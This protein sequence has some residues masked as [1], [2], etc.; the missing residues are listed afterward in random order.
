YFLVVDGGRGAECDWHF[1]S[2][3]SLSATSNS[4]ICQGETIRLDVPQ[5]APG[6]RFF[7]R[8]PNGFVSTEK[9]PVIP[10]ATPANAG[11]YKVQVFPPSG[12]LCPDTFTTATEVVVRP[13]TPL[14]FTVSPPNPCAGQEV[15]ITYTGPPNIRLLEWSF[16]GGT[17]S[18][19]RGTGPFRVRFNEPGAKIIAVKTSEANCPPTREVTITVT[20]L[21]VP[22]FNVASN[23]ICTNQTNTLLFTGNAP[24]NST[25]SWNC[26]GCVQGS[27]S[28]P[29]PHG[30]SWS[31]AG[32]KTLS[33]VITNGGCRSPEYT[34][35][36]TVNAGPAAEF[37]LSGSLCESTPLQL[38]YQG[39]V[40][41]PLMKFEWNCDGCTPAPVNT[42]GPFTIS[43]NTSGA[44]IISL[45]VTRLNCTSQKVDSIFIHP[46][47]N[48]QLS[49]VPNTACEQEIVQ[50]NATVSSATR[51]ANFV[52]S[53]QGCQGQ[54]FAGLGTAN[55]SWATAGNKNVSFFV[56]DI[57]GCTSNTAIQNV[58][59]KPRPIASFNFPNTLCADQV[60]TLS[61]TGRTFTPNPT[62]SWEC[63]GCIGL[64]NSTTAGPFSI[65]WES[66][67]NKTLR[68]Q[69]EEQGCNSAVA[70]SNVSVQFVPITAASNSPICQ[71]TVLA[72]TA[73]SLPGAL[74]RWSG[75]LGFASNFSAPS[76]ANISLEAAGQ[77]SVLAIYNNC[78]SRTTIAKVEV[79]PYPASLKIQADTV[80][81]AGSNFS[82]NAQTTSVDATFL[83]SGPAGFTSTLQNPVIMSVNTQNAGTYSLIA[84]LGNCAAPL[85]THTLNVRS[86]A[87]PTTYADTV[88]RCETG[89]V[90]FTVNAPL[91]NLVI[92]YD[93]NHNEIS[94]SSQSPHILST[95][96]A[97]IGI[98]AFWIRSQ[99]RE[100]CLS[101]P[102][103]VY[104]KAINRPM[105]PRSN[106]AFRCGEGN[107]EFTVQIFSPDVFQVNL[108]SL[109]SSGNILTSTQQSPFRFSL[110]GITT[111]V[112][113]YAEAVGEKGCQSINRAPI[114]IR[115][116]KVPQITVADVSRCGV[117][118]LLFT[119]LTQNA[120]AVRIFDSPQAT[121]ALA[122]SLTL[123]FILGTPIITTS[124]SF[125]FSAISE[126]GCESQRVSAIASIT[127]P[128][129][130]RIPN[131]E[132]C[133]AGVVSFA[134]PE[135]SEGVLR[136]YSA[137]ESNQILALDAESPYVLT[138]NEVTTT[139]T[140]YI[141]LSLGG[142]CTSERVPGVAIIKGPVPIP[143]TVPDITRCGRGP[144][145]I[146]PQISPSTGNKI[147]LY[148][149]GV[150][151]DSLSYPPYQFFIPQVVTHTN[152]AL[153]S[154]NTAIGC[155][156]AKHHFRV[157]IA[158]I[159]PQPTVPPIY[160]CGQGRVQIP[161]QVGSSQDYQVNLYTT[162]LG[163]VPIATDNIP[164]FE[165]T[166]NILLQSTELYVSAVNSICGESPRTPVT[167][168]IAPVLEVN[169]LVTPVYDQNDGKIQVEVRGGYSPYT[170][171]LN[172]VTQIS[173][174]FS[175]LAPGSYT[176]WVRDSR[177]CIAT[178]EIAIRQQ[179]CQPTEVLRIQALSEGGYGLKWR[180]VPGATQYE[181]QLR[182]RGSSSWSFSSFTQDTVFMLNNLRPESE[183]EVQIRTLCG[184]K[185]SEF[186]RT[187]FQTPV[188]NAVNSLL[189]SQV[190]ETSAVITWSA[191]EGATA[192]E[193]SYRLQN[194]ST[195]QPTEVLS[196]PTKTLNNLIRGVTY[197]VRVRTLCF[198]GSVVSDYVY[199]TF[200]TL[201]CEPIHNIQVVNVGSQS[202][203]LQWNN[204]P[205]AIGYEV[206]YTLEGGANWVTVVTST[207]AIMISNLT[208]NTRYQVRIRAVCRFE[209]GE[210]RY[211][212]F[213]TLIPNSIDCPGPI[214]IVV[215]NIT[216]T[217]VLLNWQGLLAAT[218]YMLRYRAQGGDWVNINVTPPYLL[219]NLAPAT[220]YELQV[221]TLCN[222][223]YSNWSLLQAF[224]TPLA[225][226]G[227][228][229]PKVESLILENLQLY[230][231]PS[232]GDFYLTFRAR[233]A[234]NL[235]IAVMDLSGKVVYEDLS[236]VDEG[237]QSKNYVCKHL[238]GGIY[239]IRL[240]FNG[241]SVLS[242]R[243]LIQN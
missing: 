132:R 106:S 47:P 229:T 230:P 77:Y 207:N 224:T 20:Q 193:F 81:C 125:Y 184:Q 201:S 137:L 242:Q 15:I 152:Y 236:F 160:R 199:G 203:N 61:F 19:G 200:T 35:L 38:R 17:P 16:Q 123:P 134:V 107:V 66:G 68:L 211:L 95:Q 182:A 14:D 141:E 90:T 42:A 147:R 99:S 173:N 239:F 191:M 133:G 120:I 109:P 153:E 169:A 62:F 108:Y 214:Q 41:D 174:I 223:N 6:S 1:E 49:V 85:I 210:Y 212:T 24:L 57:N 219:R 188:C 34:I 117:G 7:W 92:L 72:L 84:R 101:L 162:A 103:E 102:I 163:G 54:P 33:L 233:E 43:W 74:Y 140:Y 208:P 228:Q 64:S 185:R 189:A 4:P 86:I 165:L 148:A 154:I 159:A 50:L 128:V 178:Q 195:W 146:L 46:R 161:V 48:A 186:V 177:N 22:T 216:S 114:T 142:T 53:C 40:I 25:F 151:I 194:S 80:V 112:T 238:A 155:I 122:T 232:N 97:T 168:T 205:Y 96:V 183:Y 127:R 235:V 28:G 215:S 93:L 116:G 167:V 44:K 51:V 241:K 58:L 78:S 237:W 124:T 45:I 23:P 213:Q 52:G 180:A 222:A 88:F 5:A 181:V 94:R 32:T 65:S 138:L 158:A 179:V 87:P 79:L 157:T 76:I 9:S 139:T 105:P 37:S 217:S 113:F 196:I 11:S 70:L 18:A 73:S 192:Y 234:G 8:G 63:D 10:N 69:I 115:V 29:G 172:G 111:H 118:S 197:E 75:P 136:L 2:N 206:G 143:P 231:N 164:P 27:L 150:L 119:P 130:P 13:I 55:V 145:T 171:T 60:A 104:A 218:G 131:V 227:D 3:V 39:G 110:S 170:F 56:I 36:V 89:V 176:L 220:T 121:T 240:L 135:I 26:G 175:N 198:Q 202:V 91:P 100:G 30:V 31:T 67:G 225:R 149:E 221:R 226:I 190:N 187:G 12:T 156:S 166:S 243:L 204:S 209:R 126:D 83:W 129:L 82:L 98:T 21:P 71:G 144:V 59:I